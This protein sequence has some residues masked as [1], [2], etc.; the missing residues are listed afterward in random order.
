MTAMCTEKFLVALLAY[1]NINATHHTPL[2]LIKELEELRVIPETIKSTAHLVGKFESICS[3]SG[4]G[5]KIPNDEELQNMIIGLIEIKNFT[6]TIF[7]E[8]LE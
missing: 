8:A 7:N 5:Y 1:D 4:F 3:M 2:A 6:T